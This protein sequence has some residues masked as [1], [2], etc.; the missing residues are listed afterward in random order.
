MTKAKQ[1]SQNAEN[2]FFNIL[3]KHLIDPKNPKQ[4]RNLDF[5]SFF[6]DE[7]TPDSQEK[8]LFCK[9]MQQF[10]YIY[11]KLRKTESKA[12]TWLMLG[13]WL[14]LCKYFTI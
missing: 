12:K 2:M 9:V 14:T 13:L 10:R 1:F 11:W 4:F 3:K 6:I 5:G 8:P 7:S